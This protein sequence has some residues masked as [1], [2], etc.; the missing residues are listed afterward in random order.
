MRR[1]RATEPAFFPYPLALDLPI[2]EMHMTTGCSFISVEQKKYATYYSIY[3][4]ENI[5]DSFDWNDMLGTVTGDRYVF[6]VEGESVM[7]GFVMSANQ[8]CYPFVAPAFDRALFWE[9]TIAHIA[10]NCPEC[11][12]VFRFIPDADASVLV[13]EHNMK[14]IYAQRRMLRPTEKVATELTDKFYFAEP[15]DAD[16]DE[17]VQAVFE[18]HSAGYTSTVHTPDLEEIWEAINR[19]YDLFTKTSS[20]HI[21]TLVK[22][23]GSNEIAG[24]CI[25]GIYPDSPNNFSTIH[26]VSVRPAFRRQG[27]AE[28]MM[29]NT[30]G[31]A[32]SISPAISLGVM[33]GNPAEMLYEKLGFRKGPGYSELRRTV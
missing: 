13:S 29:R 27:V 28:A 10:D 30:I 31:K 21:S 22:C 9:R 7:G 25:A 6:V 18:A 3:T 19:R 12:M 23:A 14:V 8:L 24:V 2:G 4:S 11:E 16:R 1:A 26:Q 32:H 5:L 20:L 15:V 17:I 33:L